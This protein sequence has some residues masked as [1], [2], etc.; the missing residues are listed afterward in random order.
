VDTD[1]SY[2]ISTGCEY[3]LDFVTQLKVYLLFTIGKHYRNMGAN[4]VC[5][6]GV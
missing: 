6:L 1:C 4:V 2:Y 5:G 3:S